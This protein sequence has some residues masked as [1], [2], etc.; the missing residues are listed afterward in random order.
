[1]NRERLRRDAWVPHARAL[2]ERGGRLVALW[3][4]E[5]AE[6]Q[7]VCA[8]YAAPEGLQWAELPL[9]GEATCP[10]LSPVFPFAG[11]MQRAIADLAGPAAE[12]AADRRPWLNHGA[13]PGDAFPLRREFDGARRFPE[14]A[15]RDYPFVRVEGDGVHEIPVGPVHA[16]IIEPGHFR[17]G[18]AGEPV[19]YLQLRLFYVHKGIEKR[20]ETLPW[21]HG[22]YLAE[23]I[24]GDTAVGY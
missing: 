10:D 9:A 17:F 4:S 23:S 20:F 1:M 12:G 11:R 8:A 5:R 14:H 2:V 15:V 21:R 22:L 6:G 7:V 18:V 16:G 13:W 3:A 24:S 19:L